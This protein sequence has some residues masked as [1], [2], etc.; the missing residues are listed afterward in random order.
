LFGQ[1]QTR[2]AEMEAAV[3]RAR[4][5]D[6]AAWRAVVEQWTW[7]QALARRVLHGDAGAYQTAIEH[8]GPFEELEGIGEK[9]NVRFPG[10]SLGEAHLS[11][12]PDAVPH[13]EYT[14]RA[15]GRTGVKTMPRTRRAELVQAHVCS[16]AIRVAREMFA[17]LPLAR[18]VVH[19][20]EV[21]VNPATGHNEAYTLL[22]VEFGRE[23]LV[24]SNFERVDPVSAVESFR[25]AMNFKKS[26]GLMP[27]MEL[28]PLAQLTS[29]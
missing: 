28:E 22:S 3:V 7:L 13:I 21:I 10:P 2:R 6:E 16:A 20:G 27:V 17:L 29:V 25:H 5:E 11:A 9:V 18:V 4:A 26:T 23:K 14:V 24:D 1:A 8:L 12:R 19:V 15:S